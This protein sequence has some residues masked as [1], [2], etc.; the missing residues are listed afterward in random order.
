MP[1]K[2]NE[3]FTGKPNWVNNLQKLPNTPRS[4][5]LKFWLV[6]YIHAYNM[7]VVACILYV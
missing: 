3:T 7:Y 4:D 2:L 6:L 5:T 1:V